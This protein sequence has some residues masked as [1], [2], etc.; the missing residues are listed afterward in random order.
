MSN[1][2][3]LLITL[4][5]TAALSLVFTFIFYDDIQL[6]E[7]RYD[8][9]LNVSKIQNWS[10][11]IISGDTITK[12]GVQEATLNRK[13]A[14]DPLKVIQIDQLF[15]GVQVKRLLQNISEADCDSVMRMQ[16]FQEQEPLTQLSLARYDNKDI[17][18]KNGKAYWVEVPGYPFHLYSEFQPN[19]DLWKDRRLLNAQWLSMKSLSIQYLAP[20]RA[21]LRIAFKNSFYQVESVSRLD[22]VKLY[23]Y[24][25]TVQNLRAYQQVKDTQLLLKWQAELPVAVVNLEDLLK[26]QNITLKLYQDSVFYWGISESAARSPKRQLVQILPETAQKLLKTTAYFER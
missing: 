5:A 7:I 14:I 10:R 23:D 17:W 26:R 9:I 8:H 24:I 12:V 19:Q 1:K 15:T 11:L 16:I 4:N 18:F 2:I 20:K 6:S 13:T 25:E 22:S 3:I 21:P